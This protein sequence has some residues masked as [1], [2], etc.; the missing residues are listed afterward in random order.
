MHAPSL[1]LGIIILFLNI[2]IIVRGKYTM[3]MMAN[4]YQR[5]KEMYIVLILKENIKPLD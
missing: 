1:L 3:H 4:K 2:S 5:A